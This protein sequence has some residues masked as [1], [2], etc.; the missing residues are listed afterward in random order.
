MCTNIKGKKL[1]YYLKRA[2]G[3]LKTADKHEIR[4]VK[5]NGKVIKAGTG[6]GDIEPGDVII[7]PKKA[8][9]QIDILKIVS[10]SLAIVSSLATTIYIILKL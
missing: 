5:F 1:R 3:F 6:Y 4:V 9:K 2:G 8:E 10:E 7:V